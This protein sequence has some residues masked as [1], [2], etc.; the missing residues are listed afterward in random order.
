MLI[1]P[2]RLRRVSERAVGGRFPSRADVGSAVGLMPTLRL[3][4][5][6]VSCE[7]L[8]LRRRTISFDFLPPSMRFQFP[9][10]LPES[11]P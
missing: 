7:G 2:A 11:P 5:M 8:R 1:A 6:P 4:L 9:A 3:G 10:F